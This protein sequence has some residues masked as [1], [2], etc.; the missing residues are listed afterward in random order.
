MDQFRDA[1]TNTQQFLAAVLGVVGAVVSGLVIYFFTF[2]ARSYLG[3]SI[4]GILFIGSAWVVFRAMTSS[5]R[6]LRPRERTRLGVVLSLLGAAAV[7]ASMFAP[8]LKGKLMLLAPGLSCI[9]Y[10]QA[11]R[12]R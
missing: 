8:D 7:V 6:A 9:A 11:A 2:V 5:A 12:R 4:F 10:G 1:P 3:A